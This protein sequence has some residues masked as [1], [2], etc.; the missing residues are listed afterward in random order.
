MNIKYPPEKF[1]KDDK[2][3]V[4]LAGTIEMGMSEDWQSFITDFF[5]DE[6]NV[7]FLNPRRLD[8]DSS[9][10]QKITNPH[11]KAQVV[12]ELEGLEMADLIIMYLDPKTK[13][14]ISMLE[15]GL[16][17]KKPMIVCCPDGFW[18]KGNID[19]ICEKYKVE[20]AETLIDLVA[21]VQAE[22]SK[23]HSKGWQDILCPL[24]ENGVSILDHAIDDCTYK[25]EVI[26]YKSYFLK[27]T[28]CKEEVSTGEIDDVNIEYIKRKYEFIKRL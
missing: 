3:T 5:K 17:L 26:N 27:C 22:I 12:W 24:C 18:R 6:K 11:F 8:W 23:R 1:I 19:V 13:S 16:F 2:L 4:F 7:V 10:E 15:L 14:P 9:W 21:A 20:Q 25:N 28:D